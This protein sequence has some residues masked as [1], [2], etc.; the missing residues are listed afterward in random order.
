MADLPLAAALCAGAAIALLVGVGANALAPGGDGRLNRR[1][2]LLQGESDGRVVLRKL[3]RRPVAGDH[4]AL[5]LSLLRFAPVR[6]L[7]HLAGRAGLLT[8]IERLVAGVALSTI[9]AVAMLAAFVHLSLPVALGAG[10]AGTPLA[11]GLVLGKM[12]AAR[13]QRFDAQLPEALALISRSLRVGHPLTAALALVAREMPDP[14]GSEFG[15]VFDEMTYGLELREALANLCR[16]VESQP[17][18]YMAVAVSV[19]YSTGGNLAELLDR[20]AGVLRDVERMGRKVKALSA[21]ARLSA[22]ILSILPVGVA[23]GLSVVVPGYFDDVLGDPPFRWVLF[24]GFGGVVL[25]IAV[26]IRMIR[27]RF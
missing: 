12:G 19:Q 7:D 9:V 5:A 20:L 10:L 26:M 8:P 17:L 11:W 6:L 4:R 2:R 16:R 24:G 15:M 23:V 1:L 25:G 13:T 14:L 21:E 18:R 22:T 27:F 3:S